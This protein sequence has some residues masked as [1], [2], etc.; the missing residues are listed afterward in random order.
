MIM[1]LRTT[2]TTQQDAELEAKLKALDPQDRLLMEKLHAQLPGHLVRDGVGHDEGRGR[3]LTA[4]Y[5]SA[6]TAKRTRSHSSTGKH[7][8]VLIHAIT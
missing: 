4:S 7:Y 1:L 6:T 3:D 8:V 2:L 5:R